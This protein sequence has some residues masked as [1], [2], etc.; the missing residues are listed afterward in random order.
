MR[1]KG[2][3]LFIVVRLAEREDLVNY[4]G[5]SLTGSSRPAKY[6]YLFMPFLYHD[7]YSI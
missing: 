1:G 3:A 2:N 7:Y 5:A 4:T 6:F